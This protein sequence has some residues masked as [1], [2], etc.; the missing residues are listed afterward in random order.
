MCLE[1]PRPS[2]PVHFEDEDEKQMERLK[3]F[4]R[5]VH[6]RM[7]SPVPFFPLTRFKQHSLPAQKRQYPGYTCSLTR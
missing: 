7:K 6:V 3:K 5:I 2:G 1:E 4:L